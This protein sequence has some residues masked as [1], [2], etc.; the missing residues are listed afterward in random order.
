MRKNLRQARIKAGYTQ[1]Y[2]SQKTGIERS[3]YSRIETG[4]I[5]RVSVEDAYKIAQVLGGTIEDIFLSND[6]YEKHDVTGTEN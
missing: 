4:G 2:M 6:V 3:I 5:K 1:E